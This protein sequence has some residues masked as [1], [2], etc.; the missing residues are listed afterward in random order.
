MIG[1][2][3]IV[4]GL[5]I[6]GVAPGD[7]SRATIEHC[8]VMDS[9]HPETRSTKCTGHWSRFGA[10]FTGEILGVE[11]V[12]FWPAIPPYAGAGEWGEVAVPDDDTVRV[13]PALAVPGL[14]TVTPWMVWTVRVALVVEAVFWTVPLVHL[15][16][17]RRRKPVTA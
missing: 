15:V 3:A 8:Y 4:G 16:R 5:A 1:G 12:P 13:V 9:G 6:T 10:T 7:S 17:S 2:L 11:V 14:A